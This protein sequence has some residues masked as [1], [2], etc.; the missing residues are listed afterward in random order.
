VT[1]LRH[2]RDSQAR[3]AAAEALSGQLGSVDRLFEC[4]AQDRAVQVRAACATAL[5]SETQALSAPATQAL[6][7]L[8]RAPQWQVR[9]QAATAL[10]YFPSQGAF[11]GLSRRVFEDSSPSVQ[12]AA[13]KALGRMKWPG[14][15]NVAIDAA[16]IKTQEELLLRAALQ[17]LGSLAD[18]RAVEI[19]TQAALGPYHRGARKQA[20]ALL[21][22]LQR[23][24]GAAYAAQ[25]SSANRALKQ[26]LKQERDILLRDEIAALLK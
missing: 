23:L 13:M 5:G 25:R 20:I 17:A 3:I 26:A 14:T 12:S 18:P 16:Q 10:A 19:A 8:L 4:A 24:D 11:N 1:Q 22:Q 2:S 21:G 15:F 9:E 7:T 6:L